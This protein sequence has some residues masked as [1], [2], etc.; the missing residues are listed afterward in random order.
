[1]STRPS[2]PPCLVHASPAALDN[3]QSSRCPSAPLQLFFRFHIACFLGFFF[4]ALVHYAPC[5]QMFAPGESPACTPFYA[6]GWRRVCACICSAGPVG[7]QVEG[8]GKSVQPRVCACARACP[9]PFRKPS[10]PSDV[11][12][13]P[14]PPAAPLAAAGPAA[15]WAWM[16]ALALRAAG[17]RAPPVAA[18]AVDEATGIAT[19]Q[20]KADKVSLPA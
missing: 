19:I 15:V 9:S 3:P 13:V 17:Q 6:H 7:Y 8:D 12:P 10:P 20:L 14:A 16:V 1:M 2:A 18:A 4:F 5:W 11:D